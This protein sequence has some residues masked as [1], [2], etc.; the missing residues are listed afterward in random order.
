MC[1]SS[2][3]FTK[4]NLT[5]TMHVLNFFLSFVVFWGFTCIISYPTFEIRSYYHFVVVDFVI[6]YA[7]PLFLMA[8]LMMI[9]KVLQLLSKYQFKPESIFASML[10]FVEYGVYNGNPWKPYIVVTSNKEEK[11]CSHGFGAWTIA[12]SFHYPIIELEDDIEEIDGLDQEHNSDTMQI[13]HHKMIQKAQVKIDKWYRRFNLSSWLLGLMLVLILILSIRFIT[14]ATITKTERSH[15]LSCESIDEDFDCF[16]QPHYSYINCS[17][18]SSFVGNM[19]C[20]RYY[21]ADEVDVLDALIKAIFLFIA[22]EK[23]LQLVFTVMAT[24]YKI[25]FTKIWALIVLA[26]GVVMICISILCIV[27]YGSLDTGLL[28]ISI[29]QFTILSI[30]V[31]LVGLLL[32]FNKGYYKVGDHKLGRYRAPKSNTEAGTN[33]GTGSANNG[34]E[35]EEVKESNVDQ[36]IATQ[37]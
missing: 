11:I 31:F 14:N 5:Y 6:G 24:L 9:F 35:S 8:G 2:V 3:C 17:A 20:H 13:S 12:N 4:F 1:G 28:F 19:I 23:F 15:T 21:S 33:N 10:V 30:N 36:S 22:F 32:L 37:N 25:R 18:N 34:T 27:F 26:V 29:F 16:L 7:A